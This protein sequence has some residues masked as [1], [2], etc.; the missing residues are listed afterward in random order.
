MSLS[1]HMRDNMKF[2]RFRKSTSVVGRIIPT[3]EVD[4][5]I[6]KL[7]QNGLSS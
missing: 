6:I 1:S 5:L 3:S 4:F 2:S 7:F